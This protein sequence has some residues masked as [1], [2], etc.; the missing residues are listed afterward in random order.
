MY[1]HNP[2]PDVAALGALG[3]AIALVVFFVLALCV[4]KAVAWCMI[5]KRAGYSW[6]LGLLSLI[7]LADLVLLLVLGFSR[8]PVENTIIDLRTAL[9]Q[10]PSGRE[11]VPPAGPPIV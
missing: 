5:C 9:C 6:A 10:R 1:H 2:S 7:P 11:N 3:F 8:W 4:I